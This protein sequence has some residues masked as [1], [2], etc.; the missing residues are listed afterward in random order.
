MGGTNYVQAL[1]N[2]Q[3]MSRTANGFL[4]VSA[5]RTKKDVMAVKSGNEASEIVLRNFEHAFQMAWENRYRIFE[6]ADDLRKFI[7]NLA[8]EVNRDILKDGVLYR[9]GEDTKKYRY[10]PVVRIQSSAEWF[11]NYLFDLLCQDPY[12]A[13]AAAAAAEYYINIKT[14]FFADGCGKCSMIISAWL[15]MRGDCELPVYES[16]KDYYDF[17]NSLEHR[18]SETGSEDDL[19]DLSLFTGYMRTLIHNR[20][21]NSSRKEVSILLPERISTDNADLIN[22]QI[23]SIL[24]TV[25]TEVLVLDA[26]NLMY[27]SSAGLRMLLPLRKEYEDFSICNVC[28][29]VYV[30]L[31]MSG[32]T[33]IIKV[34]REMK[35]IS[36]EG[37]EVIGR[38]QNGTVY[39]YSPEMI[40][41]VYNEKN[42]LDDIRR[43]HELSRF[44]F[45]SGI[46]TAIPFNIVKVESGYGAMYELLEAEAL[47]KVFMEKPEQ[48]EELVN[49]YVELMKT[50]HSITPPSD[51]MSNGIF[52]EE[53]KNL[54]LRWT[55]DLENIVDPETL[56]ELRRIIRDEIPDAYTL[57]HGD[58]HPGNVLDVGGTLYFIDMDGLGTGDP[59]FDLCNIAATLYAFPSLGIESLVIND[60]ELGK[61]ILE[62]VLNRYYEDLTEQERET[63]IKQVMILAHARLMRY[64]IRHDFVPETAKERE[65][66]R[67]Y[68]AVHSYH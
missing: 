44:C 60:P 63:K 4:D 13:V 41:K 27:I 21:D 20:E 59:V 42:T 17:C 39:R 47:G 34:Y 51:D 2:L 48:R 32:F 30:I 14:H 56:D 9:G 7:E 24:N 53:K 26:E 65:L 50:V 3:V 6:N 8:R 57:L 62:K 45:I 31:D 46:P 29:K 61:E 1:K 15:L 12:D 19:L 18:F 66:R 43:E 64:T 49:Q 25:R 36:V 52:L 68:E 16:R 40:V 22:K 10:L 28:E 33:S 67:L 54:H 58:V 35:K 5:S 37:C 55:E 11:Y 38:G 23:F